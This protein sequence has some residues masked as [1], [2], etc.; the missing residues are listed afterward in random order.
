MTRQQ[1]FD[2]LASLGPDDVQDLDFL[3]PLRVDDAFPPYV[4]R[5]TGITHFCPVSARFTGKGWSTLQSLSRLEHICTPYGL[6]DDEMAGIATL[7]TV[8]EMEI[9]APRM[10]DAGP[11]SI[12]R[13]RKLQ[14]LA[15]KG[16][17][18]LTDNGL[19]PL[20]ARQP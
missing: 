20:A 5:L 3:Q 9:I 8:N 7:Q 1:C 18:N 10:T 15:I 6:T 17:S 14:V 12:A 19:K 2:C 4:A 13:L 16:G 11:A